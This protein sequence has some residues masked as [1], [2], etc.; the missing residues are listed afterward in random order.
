MTIDQ[1]FSELET[2]RKVKLKLT[3]DE[4]AKIRPYIYSEL[5]ITKDP[6][7]D[8]F[9]TVRRYR[10]P[11]VQIKIKRGRSI[12]LIGEIYYFS[13]NSIIFKCDGYDID[14]CIEQMN[15]MFKTNLSLDNNHVYT[16]TIR[17]SD[18]QNTNQTKRRLVKI[19]TRCPKC[20]KKITL[21]PSECTMVMK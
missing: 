12:S 8:T 4:S 20:R 9:K 19:H 6:D 3:P 1:K 11:G 21:K 14:L 17:K 10:S 15:K 2:Y 18:T 5:G 7:N 16:Q 13:V